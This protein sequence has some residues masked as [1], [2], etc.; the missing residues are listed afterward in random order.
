MYAVHTIVNEPRVAAAD[1]IALLL[2]LL[3]HDVCGW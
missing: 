3:L 2:L 1:V